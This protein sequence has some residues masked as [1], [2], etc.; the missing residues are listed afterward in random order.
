MKA[1]AL[2]LTEPGHLEARDLPFPEIGEDDGLLRVEAT[3]ICGS[4][5]HQFRGTLVGAP[6]VTPTIPGHEVVGRVERAGAAALARW[7]VSVGDL[8]VMEEVVMC[9]ECP[10]CRGGGPG[11]DHMRV[12]GLSVRVDEPPGLWGGYATHVYLHPQVRLHRVP[13]GMT[14]EEAALFVPIANGIRWGAT[15]PGT[16]PGSTVVVMGPGQQGLGCLVGALDAGADAVHVTGRS[17]DARRLDVARALGAASVIDVDTV[18]PVARVNE[19]T[20]G[21]GADIVID[22]TAGATVVIPQAIE[23]VRN[24]GTIVLGGLKGFAEIPGF[25]SDR[26]VLKQLRIQGVGGHDHASVEAAL[27]L[28]ASGRFPLERMRTHVLPLDQAEAAIELLE[29]TAGGLA[30]EAPIHVTLVP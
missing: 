1:H 5:V 27:A 8:V 23:M 20:G 16:G 12:Y 11:C 4:D 18:D 14:A 28:I 22:A 3:G 13:D 15:V 9:G 29:G 30:S 7:G 24:G 17:A 21:R 26:V 10:R 2:V 19:L 6:C 25:V